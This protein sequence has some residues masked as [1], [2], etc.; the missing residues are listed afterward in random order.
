MSVVWGWRVIVLYAVIPPIR[1]M[2]GRPFG[3][4]SDI[5]TLNVIRPGHHQNFLHGMFLLQ[6]LDVLEK[7]V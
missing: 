6:M 3:E 1:L 7:A 2:D 4:H 5:K